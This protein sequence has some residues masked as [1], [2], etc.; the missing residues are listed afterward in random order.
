MQFNIIKRKKDWYYI[1][2]GNSKGY[3][4][5]DYIKTNLTE[6]EMNS[7][8]TKVAVVTADG[9]NVREKAD[10]EA[11]RVDVIYQ[12]ETYPVLTEKTDW[13]KINIEDDGVKGYVLKEYV[14]LKITFKEA[15]TIEEEQ[16]L[17]KAEADK[18]VNSSNSSTQ[19]VQ[20]ASTSHTTDE[21]KL[22]ACLIQ[23]EAGNQSYEGKLAVGNVVLNRVKSGKYPNSISKVIYQPGQFTVVSSGSL[24]KQL[25]NY[26]NYNTNSHKLSI[27]AAKD[28]LAG[29]NNIGGRLYFNGYRAAINAGK[30]GSSSVKIG[31]HLFW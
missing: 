8:G 1:S 2:S 15:I 18:K 10:S 14:K 13:V 11:N 21:V 12:S 22:L 19:T 24:S 6:K 20:Q 28:A 30:G 16:A 23:A 31:D 29:K 17:A 3:V 7:Y 5:S 25:N 27:Q 4:N 26:G 9:L